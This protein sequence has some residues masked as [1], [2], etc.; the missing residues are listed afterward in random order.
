MAPRGDRRS[1]RVLR[2]YR[3][4]IY[5]AR[6]SSSPISNLELI[7]KYEEKRPGAR[8][9]NLTPASSSANSMAYKIIGA[10]YPPSNPLTDLCLNIVFAEGVA[11]NRKQTRGAVHP[12]SAWSSA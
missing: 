9:R 6:E 3:R 1:Q 12:R 4:I 7:E 5:D 2:S 8:E 11:G 10:V